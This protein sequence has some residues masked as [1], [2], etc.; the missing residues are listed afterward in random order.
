MFR[1]ILEGNAVVL[2]QVLRIVE[3]VTG[4]RIVEIRT[5]GGGSKSDI[6]NSII[7]DATGK[8]VLAVETNEASIGSAI[9]A[10]WGLTR[11]PIS[12]I[13][14]RATRIRQRFEPSLEA[15]EVYGRIAEKLLL[16]TAKIYSDVKQA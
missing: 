4:E 3:E 10:V 6:Q 5:S 16:L 8:R 14:Q 13:A 12:T 2:T 9:L 7:A 1:S 11:E 15:R